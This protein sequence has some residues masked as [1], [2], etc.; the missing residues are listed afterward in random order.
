GSE[1]STEA[2]GLWSNR[3]G[4]LPATRSQGNTRCPKTRPQEISLGDRYARGQPIFREEKSE[5]RDAERCAS[6]A[7]KGLVDGVVRLGSGVPPHFDSGG[8][9]EAVGFRFRREVL[10]V[11]STPVWSQPVSLYLHK[12]D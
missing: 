3:T 5:I 2:D 7:G 8:V 10:S 6:H 9:S 11:S 4:G 12:G 1:G